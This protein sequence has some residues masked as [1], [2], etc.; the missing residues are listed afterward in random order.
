[1][2]D[3]IQDSLAARYAQMSKQLATRAKKDA[4]ASETDA[5]YADLLSEN[6][7]A[8]QRI[9]SYLVDDK[10]GNTPALSAA[11][12]HVIISKVKMLATL[13]TIVAQTEVSPDAV[14]V[15]T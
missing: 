1:M 5:F 2:A 4:L 10:S 12:V 15:T 7:P 3:F 13:D 6:N 9:D 11:G 8:A 14:T